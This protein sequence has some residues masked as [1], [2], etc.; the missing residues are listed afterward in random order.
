MTER[1]RQL[2]DALMRAHTAVEQMLET[3]SAERNAEW[4]EAF[5]RAEA[6]ITRL[7]ADIERESRHAE[8]QERLSQP[9]NAGDAAGMMV[10]DDAANGRS[11]TNNALREYLMHGTGGQSVNM[12][13]GSTER[14][15]VLNLQPS[16]LYRATG[17]EHND[18]IRNRAL[19]SVTDAQGGYTVGDEAITR[20]VQAQADFN[21]M[22]NFAE[23]I[24]TTGG[25]DWPWPTLN[26]TGR[27]GSLLAENTKA[28]ARADL[29]FGQVVMKAYKYTSGT[30]LVPNELFE[31]SDLP[32]DAIVAADTSE[33]IAR[34]Q[35]EHYTTGDNSSK[36]QGAVTG[37]HTAAGTLTLASGSALT[38]ERLVDIESTLPE[39]YLPNA[40]FFMNRKTRAIIYKMKDS[41]GLPLFRRDPANPRGGQVLGYDIALLSEMDDMGANKKPIMFGDGRALKIREV[42]QVVLRRLLEVYAEADQIGYV[43]FARS[44][45]RVVDAGTHPLLVVSQTAA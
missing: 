24:S 42:R 21:E 10:G 40:R 13:D 32:I 28:P 39:A 41:D 33:V 20:W 31:D 18:A 9:V 7:E 15:F 2:R 37:G 5:D 16:G 23:V 3:P 14:G 29:T 36:P 27:K 38:W 45:S 19:S 17:A 25:A 8:R 4:D 34:I 11:E 1:E 43:A 12:G 30:M 22:R 26:A 35:N 44:D 6:E